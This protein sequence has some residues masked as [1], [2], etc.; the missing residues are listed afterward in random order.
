MVDDSIV[1]LAG[2]VD[3]IY[4]VTAA[5]DENLVVIDLVGVGKPNEGDLV[6]AVHGDAGQ[7]AAYDGVIDLVT[8]S[9]YDEGGGTPLTRVEIVMAEAGT[10]DVIPSEAGLYGSGGA[11][12][13]HARR[14]CSAEVRAVDAV[15]AEPW[16][17]E[18]STTEAEVSFETAPEAAPVVEAPPAATL[19]T[20]ITAQ[21][22]D[23]GVLVGLDRRWHRCPRGLHA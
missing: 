17:G 10:A 21:A 4:S 16:Q 19:L 3:P 14:G 18:A 15:D 9:V 6:G 7:V 23:G 20:D 11:R 5:S 22:T 1:T 2:L 12:R 13:A 8:L